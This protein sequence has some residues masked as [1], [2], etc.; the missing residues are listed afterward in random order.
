M[1][2]V[3]PMTLA[4]G[5]IVLAYSL[6]SAQTPQSG[7][8]SNATVRP[9][10]QFVAQAETP[11][12]TITAAPAEPTDAPATTTTEITTP[13]VAQAPDP[14]ATTTPAASPATAGIVV[15]ETALRYFA[16]QGDDRRVAAEIARLK[17]IYPG[18]N[19]PANLL[20]EDYVPDAAIEGIW[21]LFSA[22][23]FAGARAAIAAKQAAD[24]AFVP[25]EELLTSLDLGEAGLKLRQASDAKQYDT[26]ISV[27][28][29]MPALLTCDYIDNLWRLAEAFILTDNKPRGVEAYTYILTNCTVPEERFATM[30][31]ASVLLDRSDLEP[32]LA[33]EQTV[34]GIGEFAPMRLD[35]ARNAVAETLTGKT[36]KAPAGDVTLLGDSARE[37]KSAED[38]RLLGWYALNQKKPADGREWFEL[39]TEA[40]PSV[41]SAH[42]M[43]VALLDLRRPGEAEKVLADYRTDSEEITA[44][45]LTA[46]ASL[47]AQEPRVDLEPD[48][49]DRIVE[50]TVE[51]RAS[52]P[53]QELGWYSYAYQQPTTAAAWFKMALDWDPT[54]EPSAF[55]LVVAS[56]AV[57]DTAT[58][59]AIKAAW[60]A[61]SARIATFG[62]PTATQATTVAPTAAPVAA[63]VAAATVQNI[64]YE[65]QPAAVVQPAVQTTQ[66]QPAQQ[67]QASSGGGGSGGSG[68]GG[69]NCTT[70]TP[71]N[72]LSAQAALNRAW[73]LMDLDR[74]TDAIAN[75]ARALDSSNAK[76]R[77]DAA[78]G[79]SLA[80][81]RLG[82]AKDASVAASAAPLDDSRV[83]ELEVAIHTQAAVRAYEVGQYADALRS[84][85]ERARFAP[86]QNDL[87]TLRAYSYMQLKRYGEARQ[88]FKAV[89]ATGYG[90]AV[91]G[92]QAAEAALQRQ[93]QV[94]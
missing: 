52:Q 26:V 75:F 58:V 89:A 53:A 35:M 19:P 1:R 24:P 7:L 82:L 25:S 81:V 37:S 94:N 59:A 17:A 88:I 44:L 21:A 74:P 87:L 49:L 48:V 31:K 14:A 85:D 5:G 90:D 41:L 15:D 8:D 33:L 2:M 28:A 43:A 27:A 36:G 32:L 56:N 12:M 11:A 9:V 4:I 16:R 39:A 46:A 29:T 68:S 71:P 80:Y 61:R 30:Q 78:Y 42:G 70:Y 64:A 69:S 83:V 38:L 50:Q 18:W 72:S 93:Q 51:S 57:A 66:Q 67:P 47:L 34:G 22:G 45:Y 86:E 62:D 73:C 20:T 84:L 63:P 77:S 76:T 23:D 55:G 79:Q 91:A 92:L 54:S 10:A 40:D 3:L 6:V 13:T 65:Q 60:G